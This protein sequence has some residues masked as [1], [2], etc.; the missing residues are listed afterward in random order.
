MVL[1]FKHLTKL[2]TAERIVP[3]CLIPATLKRVVEPPLQGAHR[4][5]EAQKLQNL[6][7]LAVCGDSHISHAVKTTIWCLK[8]DKIFPDTICG[9]ARDTYGTAWTH[10][11]T[12]VLLGKIKRRLHQS[13]WLPLN[14]STYV[15]PICKSLMKRILSYIQSFEFVFKSYV[16]KEHLKLSFFLRR[17]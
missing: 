6:S 2:S 1:S 14:K 4:E 10:H 8:L 7:L 17:K 13:R 5:A 3:E 15:V 16:P 12:T 11:F 9:Q